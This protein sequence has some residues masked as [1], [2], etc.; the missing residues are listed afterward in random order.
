MFEFLNTGNDTGNDDAIT[1]LKNDHQK[2]KDLFDRFENTENRHE[3]QKIA[4][5]AI[6]ELKIHAAIEEQIFYPAVRRGVD[7]DL[8]N[9]ADEE[10][11]VAKVLIAELDGM[12]GTEDHFDAKFKVLSEN[13]RHHIREEEGKMLPEA[14]QADIDFVELGEQLLALKKKLM[15]TGVPKTAEER[16]VAASRGRNDS[17]AQAARSAASKRNTPGSAR[18]ATSSEK[19]KK[20]TPLRKAPNKSASKAKGRSSGT[21]AKAAPRRAGKRR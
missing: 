6:M 4:Q 11:H 9:E 13:V 3:K 15:K 19:D 10:H 12:K 7:E 14:R 8:M 16:M 1:I 18:R 21:A 2:V 17:P 5:Q 20:V